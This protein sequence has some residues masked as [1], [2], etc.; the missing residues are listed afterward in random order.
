LEGI[1]AAIHLAGENIA[2]RRWV[3]AQKKRIR[4]S[5]VQGTRLISVGL[6]E[7]KRPPRVLVSASAI[8]WYGD[9]GAELL[10]ETSDAGEGFLAGVTRDWEAATRPAS[11]AGIRVVLLR[12]G[13]IL[14]RQGGALTKMLTPFK[15][16][17]GGRIGDGQQYWSWVSIDDA[18]GAVRHALITE[19]LSGPVNVVAPEAVTN[20]EFTRTL[21]RVLRRPTLM[22]I[23]AFAARLALGEMADELLL[24]SA[25]VQPVRLME[26]GYEFQHGSLEA[27]LRHV[28]K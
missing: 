28:L 11:D 18:V 4:D 6:A 7:M 5:R 13:L 16:G 10:D 14:S 25:R 17:G 23:P 12:F 26:S 19:S 9:R 3:A 20:Q 27:A 2:A 21:G 24:A 22:P 8:G 15:L 1:D